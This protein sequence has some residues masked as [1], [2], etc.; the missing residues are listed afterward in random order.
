MKYKEKLAYLSE[1]YPDLW[2]RTRK[3]VETEISKNQPM[4]CTCGRLA[5]GFHEMNCSKFQNKVSRETYKK[6]KFLFR[7]SKKLPQTAGVKEK[8]YNGT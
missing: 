7:S 3:E 1:N 8:R 6:L 2:L 5:T 4:V